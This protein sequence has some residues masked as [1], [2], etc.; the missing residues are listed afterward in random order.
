MKTIGMDVLSVS[1][2]TGLGLVGMSVLVMILV[3]HRKLARA[4]APR[5]NVRALR[6]QY[7]SITVVRPV[8]G[9]DVGAAENFAAALD[10]GYP[11]DVE[12][13]FVFDDDNDPGLPVARAVVAEHV[14]NGRP[15]RA[16]VIVAGA[17][18]RGRTGKL[19]A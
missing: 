12:T 11:G 7:P 8:R 2:G 1:P 5:H 14:A 13:L 19:N 10:T 15:A 9:K 3:W 16:D 17:P 6:K 18:P 4:I